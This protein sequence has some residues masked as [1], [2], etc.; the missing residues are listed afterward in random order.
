VLFLLTFTVMFFLEGLW[1]SRLLPI[2][3]GVALVGMS[4]L[5]VVA[6]KLP[7]VA[8]RSLAFLPVNIDPV[9]RE[10]AK[11]AAIARGNV[12]KPAAGG[13]EVPCKGQGLFP[14]IPM[15]CSWLASRPCAGTLR[16]QAVSCH[17]RRLS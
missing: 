7:P 9:I 16:F 14:S 13:P 15:T 2:F 3:A 8:Q 6:D 17:R 12:E 1:R 4:I 11:A 10:G 5:L